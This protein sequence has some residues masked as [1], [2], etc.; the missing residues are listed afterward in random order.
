MALTSGNV[1]TLVRHRGLALPYIVWLSAVG[2]IS[3]SQPRGPMSIVDDRGRVGG[4]FNLID[5]IVAAVILVL[6]PVAYGAYLLF[7]TPPP[8]LMSI[9]P[10]RLYQGKNLRLIVNGVNLRPFMRVTF[11]TIQGRTFLIGSTTNAQVDLPDL[12]PGTYDVRCST[13]CRRCRRCRRR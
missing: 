4:R 8:E 3:S 5:G 6:I 12:A 1:G 7:R 9:E 10:A 13:T 11:N 2:I